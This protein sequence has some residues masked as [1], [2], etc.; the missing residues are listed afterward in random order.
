MSKKPTQAER[1]RA[2]K[3]MDKALGIKQGSK[4]DLK[5]D[6]LTGAQPPKKGAR[7]R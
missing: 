5:I 4:R 6:K 7:K 3:R 1:N 2:D